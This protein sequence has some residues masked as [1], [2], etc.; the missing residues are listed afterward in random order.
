MNNNCFLSCAD[1]ELQ[2]N[3]KKLRLFK[4]FEML[5]DFAIP[6]QHLGSRKVVFVCDVSIFQTPFSIITQW[7]DQLPSFGFELRVVSDNNSLK[8]F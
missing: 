4:I 1:Q 7:R 8:T 5:L 2:V 6:R 3:E